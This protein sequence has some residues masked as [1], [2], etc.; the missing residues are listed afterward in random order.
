MKSLGTNKEVSHIGN[1]IGNEKKQS[2]VDNTSTTAGGSSQRNTIITTRSASVPSVVYQ[3]DISVKN[4]F[5]NTN[6]KEPLT[7]KMRLLITSCDEETTSDDTSIDIEGWKSKR[8]DTGSDRK[9]SSE[10]DSLEESEES[11]WF[12]SDLSTPEYASRRNSYNSKRNSLDVH[13]EMSMNNDPWPINTYPFGAQ[14]TSLFSPTF[15]GRKSSGSNYT[16]SNTASRTSLLNVPHIDDN[17]F[18]NE[19][20]GRFIGGVEMRPVST[21]CSP[22]RRKSTS[23]LHTLQARYVSIW[24]ERM[25]KIIFTKY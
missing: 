14:T 2:S 22:S 15:G 1:Y 25:P 6:R 18:R 12:N 17:V 5:Q 21:S 13:G 10:M 3:E 7:T 20:E 16:L 4:H 23:S 8:Q 24:I 9:D 19:G 11:D